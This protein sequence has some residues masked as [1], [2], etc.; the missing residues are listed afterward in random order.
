MRRGTAVKK[1]VRNTERKYLIHL[2][3]MPTIWIVE[4][5]VSTALLTLI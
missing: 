5:V 4:Y 2:V 1:G 3:N